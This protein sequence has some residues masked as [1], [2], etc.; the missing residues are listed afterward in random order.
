V[1]TAS[2]QTVRSTPTP[3]TGP[4][5]CR[6]WCE[7]GDGHPRELFAEDQCCTSVEGRFVVSREESWLMVDGST[8]PASAAVCAGQRPGEAAHVAVVTHNDQG[9]TLTPEEA[10]VMAR[11]LV[12]FAWVAEQGVALAAADRAEAGR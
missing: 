2:H 10:R 7:D 8:R 6:P 3:A 4:I 5:Q 11:Q 1:A 12:H 9:V